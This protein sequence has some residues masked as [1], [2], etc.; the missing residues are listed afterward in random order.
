MDKVT[1]SREALAAVLNALNGPPHYIRELQATRMLD[2][3]EEMA[4]R[5]KKN[6]INIL[7]D[8]YN[9]AVKVYN[10]DAKAAEQFKPPGGENAV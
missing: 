10:E 8:E 7:V 6:A 1:V 2:A 4:G 3:I 5:P 9:A